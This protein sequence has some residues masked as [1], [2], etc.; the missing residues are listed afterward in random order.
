MKIVI[1]DHSHADCST[2]EG[3]LRNAGHTVDTVQVHEV[4]DVIEA[5]KD[6]DGAI[7]EYA[8]FTEEVFKALPKLKIISDYS[9]GVD[10]IDVDAAKKYHVAVANNPDY[11]FDEV[12]EHGMTMIAALL[13]N[14]VGYAEDVH[15]HIWD[16][17][18]AP[19]LK[20]IK[21]LTLGLIGCGQIPRRVAKMAH[22]FGM[23]VIGYDPFLPKELADKAGIELVSMEELGARADAVL[24]HVPL[25]KNTRGMINKTVFDSFKKQPVFVNTSRGATIDEHELYCALKDG[26]ISRAGLDVIISENP[27]FTEEIFSAPNV[28]FTPHAAFY[29][30]NAMVQANVTAA[31]NIVYFFEGQHDKVRFVYKPE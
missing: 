18:K 1:L 20:R 27:D 16:W 2:E 15:N 8:L 30:E 19:K 13:R 25:S 6:A 9:M 12:A 26:R 28:F 29:S 4:K 10:N 3:I 31:E 17:S 5:L 23:N 14:I 21:G 24:S 22:G 7:A 11:C